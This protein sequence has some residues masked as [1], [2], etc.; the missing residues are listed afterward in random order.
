MSKSQ[1]EVIY[2][3]GAGFSKPAGVPLMCEFVNKFEDIL[4]R[5]DKNLFQYFVVLKEA[6][7]TAEG[8]KLNEYKVDLEKLMDILQRLAQGDSAEM[9]AWAERDSFS[10]FDRKIRIEV[11]GELE[12]L[13]RR[14]C[15]IDPGSANLK[16]LEPLSDLM[17][18][19][20]PL[21]LFS[22]NYDD[23]IEVF[24]HQYKY[25]LEDGFALYWEPERFNK[26]GTHIQLFKLH[27]SV[28]WY[29]T[30][31]G[32]FYKIL[33]DIPEG[34]YRLVS[35]E[36]LKS[37]IAYPVAGK[38]IHVAPLAFGMS[39]FR[40]SLESA[41]QCVVIGYSLRDEHIQDILIESCRRNPRLRIIVA[42][43]NPF[44]ILTGTI[45]NQVLERAIIPAAFTEVMGTRKSSQSVFAKITCPFST[46]SVILLLPSII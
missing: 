26:P 27:G 24:C 12:R 14:D 13:I 23:V 7:A 21:T 15:I 42:C 4:K 25:N 43:P 36:K 2:L 16:Y 22:L 17:W 29:K 45:R 34:D 40:R 5:K 38:P 30:D 37:L 35:G 19:D 20:K 32:S 11:L 31:Q 44:N 46:V 10:A 3:I 9:A 28:L 39:E 8:C 41:D 1:I 18:G 33:L 6:M